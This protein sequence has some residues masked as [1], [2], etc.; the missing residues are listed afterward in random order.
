M[1]L[2]QEYEIDKDS[3]Y[4]SKKYVI[5]IYPENIDK[6]DSLDPRDRDQFINDAI[7]LY[8]DRY[9]SHRKQQNIIDKIK[10]AI[11][12]AVCTLL[13]FALFSAIVRFLMV[14]SDATN[15]Q[16]EQNFERLFDNYHLQ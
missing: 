2:K 8:L 13:I 15:A 16:M 6:I 9:H 7:D 5:K 14:Y 1:E 10:K 4:K 3:Y 11:C 12:Y